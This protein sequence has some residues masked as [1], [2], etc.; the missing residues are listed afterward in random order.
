MT[1][2]SERPID[3]RAQI[4]QLY[5]M[6]VLST[7]MI[8]ARNEEDIL[9][10]AVTSVPALGAFVAAAVFLRKGDSLI[11]ASLAAHNGTR[12]RSI[13]V[14]A[15]AGGAVS[16]GGRAWG[17][18]FPLH[19]AAGVRGYLVVCSE[20]APD[21]NERFLLSVLAQQSAVA[22]ENASL[23]HD[24]IDV[25]R[26][27]RGA[28]EDRAA[29]NE[30]LRSTVAQLER[31]AET[32]E[33]LMRAATLPDA[34][35]GVAMALHECTGL[36]VIIEDQFGHVMAD[37]GPQV[38]LAESALGSVR[39]PD[40]AREIAINGGRPVWMR[41]R[42]VA[43]ARPG[44]EAL[45][46]IVLLD[47]G[48]AA[49]ENSLFALEQAS[50]V[51]AMEL[52]HRRSLAEVEL[53]LRRDLVDDLVTGTDAAGA[54]ARAAAIGRDLLGT[55]R[56]LVASW[57]GDLDGDQILRAA[58][59]A[60]SRLSLSALSARRSGLAVLVVPG[61][62]D[63]DRFHAA[64]STSLGTAEGIIGLGGAAE[65][66][67]Q[68]PR[69]YDEAQRSLEVRR[70]SRQPWGTTSFEDLGLYRVLGAGDHGVEIEGFVQQWLG[71][72]IDYDSRRHANLVET[73]GQYLDSGGNY[74]LAS[75]QL[76]IHRSTL[77]YRLRRIREVSGLNLTDV[78]TRL[79]LH[80]ATRA[81]GVISLP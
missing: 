9:N 43:F 15:P 13:G 78:E 30:Q 69:S 35:T 65:T 81:W 48:R 27:L 64:M 67:D 50:V 25:T 56:V 20:Q 62:P 80:V 5:S 4:S 77:R 60:A 21:Q 57:S 23:Y 42:L 68:L 31:H 3:L 19:S 10:L 61:R 6:F 73:L 44:P 37:A 46:A 53:R 54:Y 39:T 58:D 72:L 24:A 52:S 45:G 1:S 7:I 28:V 75:E 59:Y 11:R 8:N 40:L 41:G 55:H 51:L 36:P 18:A 79:N 16:V 33:A 76:L 32:H 49:G 70:R 34:V 63:L 2:A 17:W 47:P 22:L 12:R 71:A 66:S 29:A 14:I 26:E 38:R 74:D